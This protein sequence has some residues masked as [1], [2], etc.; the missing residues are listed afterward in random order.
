MCNLYNTCTT[1]KKFDFKIKCF[2][3]YFFCKVCKIIVTKN[4]IQI[5]KLVVYMA[6]LKL[7]LDNFKEHLK[8]ETMPK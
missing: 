5:S 3:D 6:F 7:L 1:F 2:S 8:K 4:C